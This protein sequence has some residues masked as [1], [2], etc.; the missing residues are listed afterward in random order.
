MSVCF[1]NNCD[2]SGY[3]KDYYKIRNFLLG[4]SSPSYLFGKWDFMISHYQLQKEGISKIGL[5]E[6]D[7]DIIGLAAYDTWLG[8]GYFCVL[9]EYCHLKKE[10]LLYSKDSFAD[11]GKYKCLISD[12]DVYFQNAAEKLGFVPTEEKEPGSIFHINNKSLDY[13]LPDGYKIVS[14]EDNFDIYKYGQ[15]MWRGFNHEADGEGVYNPSK[16]YLKALE[17][18]MVRPNSN[19][20]LK[21]AVL[22]PKGNFASFCG[23]WYDEAC[24]YAIIEPL[25]T[26][27][28]HRNLGLGKA[29][30]YEGIKRCVRLG[31][32][33]AYVYSSQQFYYSIGFRPYASSTWWEAK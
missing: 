22:D 31:A 27:P 9:D 21:I 20:D 7:G 2:I 28:D 23:M 10:M 6:D 19:L 8:K 13:T 1:R 29:A 25:A 26:D 14:M 33:Y 24:E 30:A 16:E 15:V 18:E 12:S 32:K 17:N 4:L 3:A 11:N 5:W